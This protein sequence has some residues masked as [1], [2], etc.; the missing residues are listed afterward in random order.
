[1]SS[2][3]SNWILRKLSA[4]RGFAYVLPFGLMT[5]I[6]YGEWEQDALLWPIGAAI[7]IPGV[8]IRLW[9]TKHIGRRMPW[10][11]KGKYLIKTG[12]YAIVRNP[13]YVGNIMIA[14]GLSLFSELVWFVPI[15]FIYLFTLY[16]LVAQFEEKKLSDR[17]GEDYLAYLREVPRWIPRIGGFRAIKTGGFKWGDAFRSE[18]PSLYVV[19]FAILIF[20]LKEFLL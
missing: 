17:W 13:L 4:Y 20:V 1:M 8:L 12:P 2:S 11:K 10:I 15:V 5:V 18:V 16:H 19:T 14:V 6:T 3:V 7:I 9:A